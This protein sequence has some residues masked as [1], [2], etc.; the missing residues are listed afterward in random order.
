MFVGRAQFSGDEPFVELRVACR[1]CRDLV[2]QTAAVMNECDVVTHAVFMH[3]QGQLL[4][5]GTDDR[6]A[7]HN[8]SDSV[9]LVFNVTRCS[10]LFIV[11]LCLLD[12]GFA[13]PVEAARFEAPRRYVALVEDAS[14]T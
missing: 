10:L 2:R 1:A 14:A 9:A 13:Q 6:G 11:R 3:E 8:V 12:K 4:P 7:H 5:A